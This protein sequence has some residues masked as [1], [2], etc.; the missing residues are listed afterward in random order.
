MLRIRRS[1]H[2]SAFTILPNSTLR[3]ERLSYHARGVLAELLSRPDGWETNADT[4]SERARR[5]RGEKTGEGRRGMRAAIS[6]LEDAGYIVRHRNKLENG[7]FSTDLWV[8]DVPRNRDTARGTSDD[9]T[10]VDGTPATGTSSVSTDYGTTEDENSGAE[11]STSLAAAR[12][13]R[14]RE[15]ELHAWYQAADRLDDA[16][17]RRHLLTF[18]RRR[19]KIYRACRQHALS[20]IGAE[21]GGKEQL[22][23][24]GGVRL[25]DLLSYKYAL[26]H[27]DTTAARMPDW[28]VRLPA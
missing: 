25:V 27:Y 13:A 15:D 6:E 7:R 11:Y 17:L 24:D 21:P 23:R 1:S 12:A 20:Q 10:S 8:Y 2:L 14:A 22:S 28:L 4:L 18:E 9:G 19:P 5:A 3:D 26:R 16:R